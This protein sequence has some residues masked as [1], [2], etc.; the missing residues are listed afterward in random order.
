MGYRVIS[1]N[2]RCYQTHHRWHFFSFKKTAHWCTCI[3]LAT[4]SNCCSA[5]DFLSPEP[6]RNPQYHAVNG[7]VIFVLPSW[8]NDFLMVDIYWWGWLVTQCNKAWCRHCPTSKRTWRRH[9]RMLCLAATIHRK[10]ITK[11][12]CSRFRNTWHHLRILH[13]NKSGSR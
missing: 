6:S 10:S 13:V 3:V 12:H 2:V 9:A 5:L 8:I 1:T 11:G 4:Q 7:N